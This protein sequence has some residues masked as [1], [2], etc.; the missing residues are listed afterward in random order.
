VSE[1]MKPCR[2]RSEVM[3][4]EDWVYG[5]DVRASEAREVLMR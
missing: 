3:A 1:E 4:R 5:R 2:K